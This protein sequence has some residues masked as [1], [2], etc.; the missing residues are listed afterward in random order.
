MN[1]LKI[2]NN[3]EFGKIRT[4]TID[5]EPWFVGKD[6][7]VILGYS[8]P[9]KALRDHVDEEDKTLNDSFTVNG[10]KGILI[11]ESGLYS[12]ILSSKLPNAK[13]VQTL[14]NIRSSSYTP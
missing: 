2:F 11:N 6:V 13:K 14:G 5:N 12:L 10:T 3:K 8:N 4:V 1:E 9:Q 7:A